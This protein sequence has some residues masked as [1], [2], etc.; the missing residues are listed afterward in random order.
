MRRYGSLFVG[1]RRMA[2]D[3]N[4]TPVSTFILN[5]RYRSFSKIISPLISDQPTLLLKCDTCSKDPHAPE[6]NWHKQKFQSPFVGVVGPQTQG[7]V[8][9]SPETRGVVVSDLSE[10]AGP[11]VTVAIVILICQIKSSRQPRNRVVSL[12][13]GLQSW[14]NTI[15]RIIVEVRSSNRIDTSL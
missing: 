3:E 12:P 9:Y 10:F 2:K 7:A 6:P 5:R 13:L 8:G 14:A 15:A 1:F 4:L 11:K